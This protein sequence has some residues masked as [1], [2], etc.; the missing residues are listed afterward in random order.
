METP[1]LEQIKQLMNKFE[2]MISSLMTESNVP[3]LSLAI[4][5]SNEILYH[6]NF[7]TQNMST[8][9]EINS[10]SLFMIGS[11]SKSYAALAI[12]QLIEKQLLSI[13]D[14]IN[15]Y[16]P[17]DLGSK[18][19]PITIRHLMTHGSGIPNL[20]MSEI[21]IARIQSESKRTHPYSSWKDFYR[22]TSGAKNELV[23][24]PGDQFIYS[25]TGFTL[26]AKIV[27]VISSLSYEA[28]VLKNIFDPL[29]MKHSLFT[30][31]DAKKYSSWSK[32]YDQNGT[33]RPMYFQ[34]IIAGCGGIISTA[35]D[36]AKYVRMML[37]QGKFGDKTIL[38]SENIHEMTKIHNSCSMIQDVLGDNVGPE[39]YGYGWFVLNNFGGSKVI[40]H[41]G[42]TGISSAS[43]SYSPSLKIGISG[44]CNSP[45]GEMIIPVLSFM[46]YLA[47]AGKD[48]M[49]FMRF[50][51]IEQKVNQLKGK[52]VSYKGIVQIKIIAKL[53]LLWWV[54]TDSNTNSASEPLPLIPIHDDYRDLEFSIFTG[55]GSKVRVHFEIDQ[56][57]GIHLF[58]ERNHLHRIADV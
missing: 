24:N 7:G 1:T 49:K 40:F 11:S 25:N 44:V 8:N 28:Y 43:N 13:D 18:D 27:E 29:E 23:G 17:V 10:N 52:Y 9:E 22:H 19:K 30:E 2:P 20:G 48:P 4:T 41:P 5:T 39:G 54:P 47:L 35:L 33:E 16:I 3:G 45:Q 26:L 58:R 37:N 32:L 42:S 55:F 12:M 15:K 34:P 6:E 38:S 14:P 51:A 31:A 56:D 50:F 21:L 57:G 46:I 36:Q 53:G